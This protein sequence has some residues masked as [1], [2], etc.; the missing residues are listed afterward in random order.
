MI[1][2]STQEIYKY[3]ALP[4]LLYIVLFFGGS[5]IIEHVYLNKLADSTIHW[6]HLVR[7]VISVFFV[8]AIV[9]Y[10]PFPAQRDFSHQIES[11]CSLFSSADEGLVAFNADLK[12][13]SFNTRASHL[14]GGFRTSAFQNWIGLLSTM[15]NVKNE[16]E[17]PSP[18]GE[19]RLRIVAL[20]SQ[21][22]GYLL[23]L[24]DITES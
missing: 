7:G 22:S 5:E 15:L 8:A 13:L 21:A 20:Q 6:L 14:L 10:F 3:L 19:R 24:Q 9:V 1:R 4:C 11:I 12:V 23:L 16:F 2:L 17:I 18:D